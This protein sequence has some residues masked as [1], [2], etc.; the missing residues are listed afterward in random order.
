MLKQTHTHEYFSKHLLKYT[1]VLLILVQ[2]CVFQHADKHVICTCKSTQ[3]ALFIIL[4]YIFYISE[5]L[6]SVWE[7]VT[8]P[9][10]VI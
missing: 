5:Q 3:P 2:L 7:C 6:E 4:Y 1:C 9:V 10:V 8:I